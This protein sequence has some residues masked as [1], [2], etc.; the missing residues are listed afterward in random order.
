MEFRKSIGPRTLLTVAG[1]AALVLAGG[2]SWV[3]AQQPPQAPAGQAQQGRGGGGGRGNAGPALFTLIDA[4]KDGAVTRDEMKATFDKWFTDWDSAKAGALTQAELLAGLNAALPAPPPPAGGFF[5][6]AGPA[7]Q[8]QTPEPAHVQAMLAAL[9]GES[10]R[11]AEAA[12][13]GA[14]A[15]QGRRLRPLVD[16]ARREDD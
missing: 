2:M 9:P 13:Q 3:T 11:Q 4:N 15:Q 7:A 12:A 5:P 1:C 16:S 10:A 14:R 6:G 8:P